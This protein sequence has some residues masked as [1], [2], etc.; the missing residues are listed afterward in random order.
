V[1]FTGQE[2]PIPKDKFAGFALRFWRFLQPDL[3][4]WPRGPENCEG[5][6]RCQA[7][8]WFG[9]ARLTGS[10]CLFVAGTPGSFCPVVAAKFAGPTGQNLPQRQKFPVK[11]N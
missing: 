11:P 3:H 7:A 8:A 10:I 5:L 2:L 9:S 4:A 6:Q 1:P